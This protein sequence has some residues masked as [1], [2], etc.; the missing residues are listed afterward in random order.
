MAFDNFKPQLWSD[1]ILDN[2]DK[3]LVFG[4]LANRSYEGK[5]SG[6]G[7]SVKISEVGDVTVNPYAGSVSYETVT[8]AY[9]LLQIN[10]SVYAAVELDDVDAVQSNVEL[11][12]KLAQRMGYAIADDIDVY[13]AEMHSQ[14]GIVSGSS[15]SVATVTSATAIS[16]I[17]NIGKLMDEK[18]VPQAGRVMVIPPWLK[19]KLTLAKVIRDTDNSATLTNGLLGNFL[20]FEMYMSNNVQYSGT[21][22]WLPMF[23][24]KDYTISFAQQI[25]KVEA[26]R[27]GTKFAD[28]MRTLSVYGGKVLYPDTLGIAYCKPGAED[29]I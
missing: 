20:G 23:F 9:K 29:A 6:Q 26:L 24:V 1:M 3:R 7:T 12:N 8:D 25:M 2:L 10:Q 19:E 15:S 16:T 28:Q 13:L 22:Y 27:A 18:N 5:I 4:A 21:T 11:M 14:A 17:T